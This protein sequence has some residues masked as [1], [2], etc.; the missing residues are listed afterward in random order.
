MVNVKF[1]LQGDF[2]WLS[3][4]VKAVVKRY[5]RKLDDD[6]EAKEASPVEGEGEEEK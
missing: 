3:C 1:V 2:L 5:D 4:G 6:N